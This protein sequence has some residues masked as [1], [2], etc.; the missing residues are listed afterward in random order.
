MNTHM[1]VSS[2]RASV[3]LALVAA[4]VVMTSGVATCQWKTTGR[5][6]AENMRSAENFRRDFLEHVPIGSVRSAV[7]DYLETAGARM[8][9]RE[10]RKDPNKE[11][12][13]TIT[14]AGEQ[15]PHWYCGRGEVGILLVVANDHLASAETAYWSFNCP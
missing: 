4:S 13:I 9:L 5:V 1:T 15:S 7:W 2:R 11:V 14:L 8:S 3:F 6:H 10:R 12:E